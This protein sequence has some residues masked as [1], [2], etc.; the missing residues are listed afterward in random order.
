[1]S[2]KQLRMCMA[3]AAASSAMALPA[4]APG[5]TPDASTVGRSQPV[6]LVSENT[7]GRSQPAPLV[8]ENVAGLVPKVVAKA[9]AVARPI[10]RVTPD[11]FDW[12]DAGV[13]AGAALGAI[14]LAA[15]LA[16]SVRHRRRVVAV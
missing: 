12:R 9:H 8:S 11:G 5:G 16:V 10:V 14:L 13:G 1:M 15:V 7:A 4:Q 6:P 2:P 3:A